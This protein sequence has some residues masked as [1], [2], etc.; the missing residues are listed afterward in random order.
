VDSQVIRK[1]N[2]ATGFISTLAGTGTAGA[3]GD[4]GPASSGALQAP[5][6]LLLDDAGNLYVADAGGGAIRKIDVADPPALDFADTAVGSISPPQQVTLMNLG[7]RP[8]TVGS[9]SAP[10]DFSLGGA[11]ATC[12]PA[13]DQALG[14]AMSCT[15][16]VLFTPTTA[17]RLG[18]GIVLGAGSTPR[19]ISLTGV[20]PGP[21][22]RSSGGCGGGPAGPWTLVLLGGWLLARGFGG[23]AR[24]LRRR[25]A[26]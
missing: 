13:G 3:G 10:A 17:G 21:A 24:H 22:R 23:A 2:A 14:P 20:A 6:G 16:G 19:T 18:G 25:G 26:R 4:G 7:D 15:L 1:V 12:S 5:S 9:F 8:W 11:G